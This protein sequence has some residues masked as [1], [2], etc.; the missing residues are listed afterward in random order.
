[1]N[2]QVDFAVIHQ[3]GFLY[4]LGHKLLG[5]RSFQTYKKK[6]SKTINKPKNIRGTFYTIKNVLKLNLIF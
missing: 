4:E 6:A 1:M 5:I 2:K 3:D